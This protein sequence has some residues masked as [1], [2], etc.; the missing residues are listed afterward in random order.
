MSYPETVE[1]V[2]TVVRYKRLHEAAQLGYTESGFQ[3]F[4]KGSNCFG[5]ATIETW[6]LAIRGNFAPKAPVA[7]T[8]SVIHL[9][10]LFRP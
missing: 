10:G 6:R 5:N 7:I 2:E 9:R 4:R 1:T 3:L 8:D